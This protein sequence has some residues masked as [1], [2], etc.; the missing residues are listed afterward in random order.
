MSIKTLAQL[1]IAGTLFSA[2]S[3][4]AQDWSDIEQKAQGQTVYFHAWGGSET[5]NDYIRW[6]G[7]QVK[8]S[9]DVTLKHVRVTETGNV[10]SQVLSEKTAGKLTEGAVDLVWIN[11]ENFRAMKQNGL[12]LGAFTQK[13]PNYAYVDTE[14]KP[15]T[16]FDFTTSVDNM[17]AP[18]GMAQ[19]VFMYDT[20]Q[21]SQPPKNM[22]QL[23]NYAEQNPGRVTYPAPPSFYGTT[24]IKQALLELT[25]NK[26]ALYAPVAVS[27]F[28]TVTAPL[29]NYLDA[30]HPHMW[31]QGKTFASG[32]PQMKQ[33]LNDGELDISLSFNPN[34]ASNAIATGELPES[35][36]TYVHDGGS[37][38]NT[39]FVT[40]P[41]NSSN[42]AGAMV[43]ANFLMSPVAQA[44]KADPSIWGDPTVLST[45]KLN[46]EDKALFESLP[47]GQATLSDEEL[48]S[49]LREPHTSWVEA[50][51]KAW[52]ARYAN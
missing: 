51:E 13:L 24:F 48:G 27:D 42:S 17:E 22:N 4:F 21:V 46:A 36:R 47:L 19:L 30:L 18:W 40:I 11:G 2:T 50:L 16:L 12:L 49:V 38:G 20:E 5:I 45:Q 35:I 6:A 43:V 1:C 39:H 33:L 8:K 23:L 34:D 15:T 37:I 29:W 28:D 32:A 3:L 44:R 9:H 26:E 14:N 7:E 41:F 31:G 52:L 10:V 25:D